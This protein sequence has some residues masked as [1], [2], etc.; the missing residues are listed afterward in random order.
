M[1]SPIEYAPLLFNLAQGEAQRQAMLT[2]VEQAVTSGLGQ[3]PGSGVA[4]VFP[5]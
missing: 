2:A 3:V 5:S 1:Q 4:G